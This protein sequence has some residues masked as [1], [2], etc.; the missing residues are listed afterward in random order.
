MC[1]HLNSIDHLFVHRFH[2]NHDLKLIQILLIR[3]QTILNRANIMCNQ[4]HE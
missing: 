2:S 1:F 3:I 4:M